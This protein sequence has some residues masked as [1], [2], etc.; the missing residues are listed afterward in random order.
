MSDYIHELIDHLKDS[1]HTSQFIQFSVDIEPVQLDV[2]HCVPLGLILNE[3]ITNSIRHAFPDKNNPV[4]AVVFK[5]LSTFHY[6]LSIKDNGVGLPVDFDPGRQ[7]SM[8]MKLMRGLGDDL[9]ATFQ[10]NNEEG[11]EIRLDF[12]CE[13]ESNN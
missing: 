9:D 12:I 10:I 1:F 13:P 7:A 6:L 3:A 8:G 4:I 5:R 2:S 11:T